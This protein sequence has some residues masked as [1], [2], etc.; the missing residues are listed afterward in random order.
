MDKQHKFR[1]HRRGFLNGL[2]GGLTSGSVIAAGGPLVTS[3]RAAT[4]SDAEKRKSL[5]RVTDQVMT[6]YRVNRYPT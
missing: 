2:I 1:V 6:Y 5:Y 3:A 4:A